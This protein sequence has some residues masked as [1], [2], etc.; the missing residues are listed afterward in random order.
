M[1]KP[2]IVG[3]KGEIG[4]FIL[5]GLLR[6]MPKALNIFCVDVNESEEEVKERIAQSD[7]IFLCV[8]IDMTANWIEEHKGLL[9]GKVIIEQC[10]L[11]EDILSRSCDLDVRSMHIL[12]RPSQTPNFKDRM[13]GLFE[14]QFDKNM[15]KDMAD[16]TQSEIVWYK[17]VEEHDKEMA[18][19]QALVHRTLLLLGES[20]RSCKGSTFV[21]KKVIGL[22]DRIK[23]GDLKLYKSIQENK[24]LPEHLETLEKGFDSFD[25]EEHIGV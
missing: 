3:Y 14:G 23:K 19:Q 24:H 25:I 2:L 8:P 13:V 11:K 1:Q 22:A 18:I 17:D 16:I 7:V 9:K 6:I 20:L 4:S 10:S 15:A 5:N 12:F 21:S